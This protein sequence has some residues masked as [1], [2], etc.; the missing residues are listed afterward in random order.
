M[1]PLDM[2]DSH[3]LIEVLQELGMEPAEAVEIGVHRG[4]LSAKLLAAFPSMVLYMC[5]SWTAHEPDSE[6][7]KS[8][9]GCAR[10]TEEQQRLNMEEAWR[11]TEFAGTRARFLWCDSLEAASCFVAVPKQFEVVLQDA[12]HDY[13]GVKED[14]EAWWPLVKD[15]GI[16]AVHDYDH[17]KERRNGAFGVKRAFDE[18]AVSV[19]CDVFSRGSLAWVEK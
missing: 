17:P 9:D 11:V 8:G 5:D 4:A 12:R 10:L 16:L 13:E 6:Y 15:G 1:K 14:L 3:L 19:G 18:F 2:G 7:R